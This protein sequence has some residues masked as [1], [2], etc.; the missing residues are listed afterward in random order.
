MSLSNYPNIEKSVVF[1]D[2][3][4][5]FAVSVVRLC[6]WIVVLSLIFALVYFQ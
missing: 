3:A 5:G 1:V 2:W 4:L 6:I